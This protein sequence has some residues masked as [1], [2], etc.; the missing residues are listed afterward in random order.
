[1]YATSDTEALLKMMASSDPE[2]L[3][4]YLRATLP[5]LTAN[6]RDSFHSDPMQLPQE[7]FNARGLDVQ[8]DLLAD[9][10]MIPIARL[11]MP[12]DINAAQRHMP[13]LK[14]TDGLSSE[15]TP[16]SLVAGKDL[17]AMTTFFMKQLRLK[18]PVKS[19]L[20]FHD[21]GIVSLKSW[22]SKT[23]EERIKVVHAL[24]QGGVVAS[25]RAK[26]RRMT[27]DQVAEWTR[28]KVTAPLPP[29]V[30]PHQRQSKEE[31]EAILGSGN[32]E[33]LITEELVGLGLRGIYGGAMDLFAR[34]L[35]PPEADGA[36]GNEGEAAAAAAVPSA[37]GAAAAVSPEDAVAELEIQ[38]TIYRMC[39]QRD[40]ERRVLNELIKRKKDDKTAVAKFEERLDELDRYE[41]MMQG[42]RR[43]LAPDCKVVEMASRKFE[44][45]ARCKIAA[46]CSRDCQKTDWK[47]HSK[48]CMPPSNDN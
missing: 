10:D 3:P 35:F 16:S 19:A 45:C 43:C 34:H 32:N 28:S 22:A 37:G 4:N 27:L 30:L 33:R 38:A 18:D 17:E 42:A 14:Q 46:Y 15:Q 13:A 24:K 1:M 36:D 12:G 26:L 39:V 48:F 21:Q 25:D 20:A 11:A 8:D 41:A 31:M 23:E 9:D 2:A 29:S 5:E 47:W 7:Q 44:I 40:G 6:P